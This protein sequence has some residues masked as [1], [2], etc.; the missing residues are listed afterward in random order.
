MNNASMMISA[1]FERKKEMEEI[2][3]KNGGDEN[4][5][6]VNIKMKERD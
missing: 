6:N 2:M 3:N 5:D 4:N 1:I